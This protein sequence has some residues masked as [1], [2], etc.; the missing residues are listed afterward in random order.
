LEAV[1]GSLL[2]ERHATLSV[3]ESCTGG[4]LGER[5]T[6]VAGSSDYFVGGFV[7]YTD[8]LKTELV[9]VDPGLIAQHSPVSEPVAIAMALGALARTGSTYAISITGEAGPQSATGA[10]VGT[11]VIGIAGPGLSSSAGAAQAHTYNLFGDRAGIRARA[12]IW[13]LDDLRRTMIGKSR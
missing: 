1:V 3:A 8:R 5:I 10:P 4:L 13:A 6:S 12:A 7:T 2:R 11:V 9:G